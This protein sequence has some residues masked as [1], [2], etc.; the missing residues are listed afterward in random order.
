MITIPV[1]DIVRWRNDV[2]AGNLNG[3]ARCTRERRAGGLC[4][5]FA[6][7]RF[8]GDSTALSTALTRGEICGSNMANQNYPRHHFFTLSRRWPSLHSG[9]ET[10]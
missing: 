4:L 9:V 7:S 5:W 3:Y 10:Q 8:L 1:S 2:S 6:A